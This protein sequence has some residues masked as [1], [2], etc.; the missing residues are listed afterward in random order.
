MSGRRRRIYP[1]VR[2][3]I[4]ST[5]EYEPVGRVLLE[6]QTESE[7]GDT[8]YQCR[9]NLLLHDIPYEVVITAHTINTFVP[10][11]LLRELLPIMSL[12]PSHICTI[13]FLYTT[14]CLRHQCRFS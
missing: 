3:G 10:L 14:I 4:Q 13:F 6:N 5:I 11:I 12:T 7:L 2:G 9:Q 1:P 8:T